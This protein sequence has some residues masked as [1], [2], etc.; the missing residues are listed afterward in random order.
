M[1]CLE[2]HHQFEWLNPPFT[3]FRIL[4]GIEHNNQFTTIMKDALIEYTREENV[5]FFSIIL[6]PNII[7]SEILE[8]DFELKT[9]P[10]GELNLKEGL[11]A[12]QEFYLSEFSNYLYE[13]TENA[14]P[15]YY[16]R[17]SFDSFTRESSIYLFTLQ[18][19]FI[20]IA[21]S[22]EGDNI[23]FFDNIIACQNKCHHYLLDTIDYLEVEIEN[24]QEFKHSG[25]DITHFSITL[26]WYF[27][28]TNYLNHLGILSEF[29]Y[30]RID[31]V[32]TFLENH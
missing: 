28:L 5:S 17:C 4:I 14:Q 3:Q 10:N 18:D 2:H 32:I 12:N 6:D 25:I 22:S 23:H 27:D 29:D 8:S 7:G 1:V 13:I 19:A 26:D 20:L 16:G 21:S 30:L 9:E 31:N 24:Y 15:L 11:L